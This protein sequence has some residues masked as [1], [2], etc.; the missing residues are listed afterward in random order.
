MK[1]TQD[2]FISVL[3]LVN[4]NLICSLQ[5]SDNNLIDVI[6]HMK[7]AKIYGWSADIVLSTENKRLLIKQVL[8]FN[9]EEKIN[10]FEISKDDNIIFI[11]YDGFEIGS[12]T[13]GI[14]LP[15]IFISKFVTTGMCCVSENV[16]PY[17]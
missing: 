11:S 4:D 10:Y 16:A 2:F 1:T 3:Q 17:M 7:N 5:T 14:V 15:D 13:S 6:K 9:S 8:L 12:I